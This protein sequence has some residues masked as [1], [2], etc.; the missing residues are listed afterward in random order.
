MRFTEQSAWSRWQEERDE[1]A[2]S[3]LIE[4]YKPLVERA[5]Y[6][7]KNVRP[8]DRDDLRAAGYYGLIC[9]VDQWRPGG[10]AWEGF[11]LFKIRTAQ[12]DQIRAV[13]WV[14]KAIRSD[15][16]RLERAEELLNGRLG[17]SPTTAEL[18]EEL[19]CSPEQCERLVTTVRST[20]WIVGS[21]EG[22]NEADRSKYETLPDPDA[23]DP[24]A[25]TL[26]E[27]VWAELD[28]VLERLPAPNR[29]AL[30]RRFLADESQKSIAARL[31]VHDSRASQL[32]HAG[33]QQA[34]DLAHQL[35]LGPL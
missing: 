20:D 16:D 22:A 9:A 31:G 18:A 12:V 21:L 19:E 8:D 17:R 2:R 26:A 3:W 11:A 7:F 13:S 10:M 24:E 5:L 35:P 14:P 29:E 25:A 30:Q 34:R 33:L 23:T 1:S 28:S 32:V 27:E 15:A 4:H 6:R